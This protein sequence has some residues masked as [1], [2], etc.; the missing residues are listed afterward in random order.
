MSAPPTDAP[1]S[2]G[3]ATV[4][5]RSTTTA[6]GTTAPTP[7]PRRRSRGLTMSLIPSPSSVSPVTRRRMNIPGKNDVHQKPLATSPMAREMS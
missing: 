1:S 4:A 3:V 5:A 7:T 6:P 2:S